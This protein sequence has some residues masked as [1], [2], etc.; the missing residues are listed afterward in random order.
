MITKKPALSCSRLLGIIATAIVVSLAA[1]LSPAH[2][3][4]CGDTLG[5]GGRITLTADLS[6]VASPALTVEG[7]FTLD[8]NGHR[9]S[10]G[11]IHVRGRSASVL[12][13]TVDSGRVWVQDGIGHRLQKLN[14]SYG[15]ILMEVDRSVLRDSTLQRDNTLVTVIGDSN[16]LLNN[17]LTYAEDGIS[18]FGDKNTLQGNV[19]TETTDSINVWGD[20]NTVNLNVVT[21]SSDGISLG[22]DGNRLSRNTVFNVE[23]QGISVTGN[24]N[25]L[26]RNTTNDN[27]YGITIWSGTN[28][29]VSSNLATGNRSFDLEGVDATTCT[30]N[31]WRRN[32]FA[33]ATPACI[34]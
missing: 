4:S 14:I 34:R 32:V 27:G 12:N 7:P 31:V 23:D 1:N 21:N 13:G 18:V 3:V 2:A 26:S 15:S 30:D 19:V 10:G 17:S 33:T 8:L 28:N 25:G 20:N 6:C 22:G 29:A 24:D 16:R 5:P 9:L 11:D